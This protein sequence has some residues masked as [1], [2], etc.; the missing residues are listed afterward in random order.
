LVQG[1]SAIRARVVAKLI[2]T[3]HR[4]ARSHGFARQQIFG[5]IENCINGGGFRRL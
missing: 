1:K 3:D 4:V 2:A 5:R